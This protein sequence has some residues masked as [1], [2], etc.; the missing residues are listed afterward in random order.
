MRIADGIIKSVGFVSCDSGTLRYAGA[1][2][3]VQVPFNET[4]GC[5]CSMRSICAESDGEE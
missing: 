4:S 1:A 3:I 2:F 5:L